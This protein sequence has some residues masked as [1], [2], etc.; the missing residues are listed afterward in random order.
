MRLEK[1]KI[2]KLQLAVLLRTVL[3][4]LIMGVLIIVVAV[5]ESRSSLEDEVYR[6]LE[7]VASSVAA[8]YDEMYEGDYVLVGDKLLSLYKGETELTGRFEFVDRIKEQ[9][10]MDVTLF[11]QDARIL[12][13]L[14]DSNGSRYVAT[15]VH[16]NIMRAM[17]SKQT[18]LHFRT[19]IDPGHYYYVCYVPLF[20]S[21][22]SLVGMVGT[23][24]SA[25]EVNREAAAASSPIF[26]ITILGLLVASFIS[27]RYTR[28]IVT[29]VSDI[30]VFL[31]NMVSGKLSNEM[32]DKVV[33]RS[34]EIASVGQDIVHMQ[35]AVRVL[36]E[37]D[38]LTKLYNRRSGDAKMK[39]A[40]KRSAETGTPFVIAIGDIDF[41]KKVNDTYGHDAGDLVLKHVAKELKELMNGRGH[42]VRWGG[43][44]FLLIFENKSLY[45]AAAALEDF[46]D[47]IRAARLNYMDQEIR[48]TMTVGLVDGST[49]RRLEDMIKEADEKLYYG[50]ENG[51]NQ[52][53]VTPGQEQP[54]YRSILERGSEEEAET[55]TVIM[56]PD[57]YLDTD[58]LMQM[59]SDNAARDMEEG[60][61]KKTG[62][63]SNEEE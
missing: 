12:T 45:Q 62:K 37:C 1:E 50:K 56:F 35:N 24:I 52:L 17:E 11:Y 54:D 18:K 25:S 2:S 47:R 60:N 51:R 40:Q 7:A 43:E 61:E 63:K 38:P 32:P 23:A 53:V 44:E 41:F 14:R 5:F 46:L 9:S 57:D 42:A 59:L 49:E 58:N 19:E 21:D 31:S 10:G 36:V 28:G 33:R 6:S 8:G 29:A 34:D 13:T 4:M 15:G 26:I 22:K 16:S 48:V 27:I 3:P 39:H 55:E 30:Q 20:N